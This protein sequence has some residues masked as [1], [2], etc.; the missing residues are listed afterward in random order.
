MFACRK[1]LGFSCPDFAVYQKSYVSEF[2][3]INDYREAY[4]Y[5]VF[6]PIQLSEDMEHL[7]RTLPLLYSK[8]TG[9]RKKK[10]YRSN[11]HGRKKARKE[12][13]DDDEL[14]KLM[15]SLCEIDGGCKS[16]AHENEDVVEDDD[17]K[18]SKCDEKLMEEWDF[19]NYVG[20]PSPLDRILM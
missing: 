14:D 18:P 19:P 1:R 15:I 20:E 5:G 8:K 9:R 13:E 6:Y 16:E 12:Y 2:F 3:T 7:K 11:L 10:H 4:H 17:N